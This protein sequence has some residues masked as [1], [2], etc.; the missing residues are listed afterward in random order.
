[1]DL[2]L[3]AGA[4]ALPPAPDHPEP[5]GQRRAQ[6]NYRPDQIL[7]DASTYGALKDRFVSNQLPRQSFKNIPEY[8]EVYQILGEQGTV[9]PPAPREESM[10]KPTK[11]DLNIPLQ[12][13]IEL[14]AAHTAS[15]VG[16]FIGLDQD[17]MDEVK[18]ALIEACINAVEHSKSKD[19]R[20]TIDFTVEADRLTIVISDRGHGF[21]KENVDEQI[22]HR[23]AQGERRGWG[24][25]LMKE[26][27]DDV[28]IESDKTGTTI[29]MIKNR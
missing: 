22:R 24:L 23:R 10:M 14:M 29:T 3:P 18:M 25:K 12:P 5:G 17:K 27:M 19:E 6:Q 20:L 9:A 4:G 26:L 2:R 15:G 13:D 16:E 21:D 1:M 8:H 28:K 11:M 7:V